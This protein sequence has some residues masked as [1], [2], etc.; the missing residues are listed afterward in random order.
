VF[1]DDEYG[2]EEPSIPKA[3]ECPTFGKGSLKEFT[4]E[5]TREMLDRLYEFSGFLRSGS[6]VM[7]KRS[8]EARPPSGKDDLKT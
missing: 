2:A 7:M 3:P 1:V 4:I 6:I 5:E 8:R